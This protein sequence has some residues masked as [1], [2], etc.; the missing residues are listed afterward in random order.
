MHYL[1]SFYTII[2]GIQSYFRLRDG[3]GD[4]E[5]GAF[6]FDIDAVIFDCAAVQ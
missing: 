4:Q 6:A 3:I 1:E 2:K 5:S